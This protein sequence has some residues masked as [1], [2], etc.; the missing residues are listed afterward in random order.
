MA[1]KWNLHQS[2][3]QKLISLFVKLMFSGNR[4]SLTELA[5]S[6]DCSKQTVIRIL[7]DIRMAYSLDIEETFEG[8]RK[9]YRIKRPSKSPPL[10]PLTDMEIRTLQMCRDFTEHLLGKPLYEEA[11]H[12]L[13]KSRAL[14]PDNDNVFACHFAAFRP[15]TTD[16]T[17]KAK[18]FAR[19][20]KP[21]IKK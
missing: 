13:L 16:Y 12:A 8:N 10:I 15:G 7:N 3:G 21:W 19:S 5:R 20:W 17:P 2:Y 9:Y 11:T 6:H 4:Y 1:E 14:L 18:R